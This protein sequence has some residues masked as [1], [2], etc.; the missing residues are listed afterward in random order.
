MGEAKGIFAFLSPKNNNKLSQFV[1]VTFTVTLCR[2]EI[3]CDS[4]VVFDSG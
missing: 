4:I 3:H 1:S 2:M